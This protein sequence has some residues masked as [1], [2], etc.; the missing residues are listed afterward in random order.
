MKC[1]GQDRSGTGEDTEIIGG[2]GQPHP[3]RLIGWADLAYRKRRYRSPC[4]GIYQGK[5][6]A[7]QK[8][9]K[10]WEF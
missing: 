10:S 7:G 4:Q 3:K 6:H 9:P 2:P 5:S 8:R 1:R